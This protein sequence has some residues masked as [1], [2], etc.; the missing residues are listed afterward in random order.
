VS[1]FYRD[2]ALSGV[3]KQIRQRKWYGMS[4][5]RFPDRHNRYNRFNGFL[6]GMD[7]IKLFIKLFGFV[8]SQGIMQQWW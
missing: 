4:F 3:E 8:D 5:Y 1:L 6:C 7:N 2:F